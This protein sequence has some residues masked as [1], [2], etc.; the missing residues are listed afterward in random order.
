VQ[1]KKFSATSDTEQPST[2][3]DLLGYE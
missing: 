3:T 1:L 2:D